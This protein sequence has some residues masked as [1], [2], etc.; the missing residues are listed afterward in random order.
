[1]RD[2]LSTPDNV[3]S[4]PSEV[5]F[6][7]WCNFFAP[8]T[9]IEIHTSP[10]ETLPIF[11]LMSQLVDKPG[12]I[13]SIPLPPSCEED[14][15]LNEKIGDPISQEPTPLV[16]K[17]L[18][19][20]EHVLTASSVRLPSSMPTSSRPASDGGSARRALGSA[21]LNGYPA[22]AQYS[23]FLRDPAQGSSRCRGN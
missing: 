6:W 23:S 2:R 19:I 4:G 8:E 14:R 7:F 17:G 20:T 16:F 11:S 3:V 10:K 12:D 15:K 1:M 9:G 21:R 22:E 18:L 13:A 5:G